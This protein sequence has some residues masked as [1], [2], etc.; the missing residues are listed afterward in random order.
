MTCTITG[1]SLIRKGFR[2]PKAHGYLVL[3]GVVIIWAGFALTIR[4]IG[5]SALS[6]ADVAL[7]RFVVPAVTLLAFLPRRWARLKEV[8]F[9]D[10]LMIWF[11]GVPFF[12]IATEGARTTSAAHVG[13]LIAGTA[14]LSVALLGRFLDRRAIPRRQWMPLGLIVAGAIGIAAARGTEGMGESLKGFG[15][16]AV[17]SL[18]WGTYTLGV[19]R[20]GLDAIGNTLPLALGSLV[21][22][23]FTLATGITPSHFGHFTFHQALPFLLIQGLGVGLL[24]TVGYAFAITR[25]GSAKSSAIGSLAPALAAIL[26]VPVL[27]ESLGVITVLSIALITLGV[28]LSNRP[29]A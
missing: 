16:L 27:G 14:P 29:S 10:G 17:A 23:S 3:Y 11:G 24:A 20:T 25:L 7:M 1:L 18:L 26:A 8:R 9:S 19:K 12:F 6:P 21:V 22:L 15:F 2:N 28:V 5:A 4:A 13:A